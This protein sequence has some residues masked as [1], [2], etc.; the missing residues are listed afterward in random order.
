MAITREQVFE[1]CDQIFSQGK[2]PRIEA[3]RTLLGSGSYSTIGKYLREWKEQSPERMDATTSEIPQE[4]H[5]IAYEALKPALALIWDKASESVDSDRI[6]TLEAEN[7]RYQE[8]TIELAGLR[9]TNKAL[10]EQLGE[11]NQQLALARSGIGVEEA[12]AFQKLQQQRDALLAERD[13]LTIRI[14]ELN[15]QLNEAASNIA[16]LTSRVQS[17]D[18]ERQTLEQENQELRIANA[19]VEE[20]QERIKEK[21]RALAH[22]QRQ[23]RSGGIQPIEVDV[24]VP[25]LTRDRDAA[26]AQV[27][28]LEKEL[29]VL[30]Q[31][32]YLNSLAKEEVAAGK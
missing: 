31:E 8:A 24:D 14:E 21:D 12:Q 23:V 7:E 5:N 25:A 26:L 17:L 16:V 32:Q 6:R 22:L 9:T 30:Q 27:K 19:E 13:Q 28:S 10:L 2:T 20:L 4:L 11:L 18:A 3:I 1:A 29:E 15:Q